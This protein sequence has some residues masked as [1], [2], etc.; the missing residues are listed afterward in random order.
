MRLKIKREDEEKDEKGG[1][2]EGLRG[3]M[4]RRIKS[5]DEE[6]G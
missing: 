3:R 6:E 5:E 4:R 1:C 2:G